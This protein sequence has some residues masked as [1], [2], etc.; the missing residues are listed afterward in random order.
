MKIL[1]IYKQYFLTKTLQEHMI[2]AAAV[3]KLIAGNSQGI[4]VDTE[5][6]I[7]VLLLHDTG[8]IIKFDF[9]KFPHLLGSE[10]D[11]IDSWKVTQKKFIEKFGQ[12]EHKA[13]ELIAKEIGVPSD[14]QSLLE[15]QIYTPTKKIARDMDWETKICQYADLRSGPFGVISINERFDELIN[16]YKHRNHKI[17]NIKQT[18]ENRKY[19][20]IIE[21]QLQRHCKIK[22]KKISE[23]SVRKL[24]PSIGKTEIKAL[25]PN[26]R[27]Q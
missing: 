16:R 4:I 23:E 21:E 2:R 26:I 8:N 14:I 11:E 27:T 5:K 22:L 7:R 6:I 1:Q 20:L 3:G 18:E 25:T 19:M 9:D 12:E 15:R 17:S 10:I 13:T 24:Y